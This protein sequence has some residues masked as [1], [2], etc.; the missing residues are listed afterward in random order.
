MLSIFFSSVGTLYTDY[1]TVRYCHWSRLFVFG[2]RNE[3]KIKQGKLVLDVL[4]FACVSTWYS[5]VHGLGWVG[6]GWIELH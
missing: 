2:A 5:R 6:L 3:M 4:V 1:L